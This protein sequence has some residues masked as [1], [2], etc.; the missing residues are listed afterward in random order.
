[1]ARTQIKAQ[2]ILDH[3]LTGSSFRT[4]L[5]YYD[6]TQNYSQGAVISWA[7][8]EYQANTSIT[9]TTEGDL[10]NAPNISTN[11][12]KIPPVKCLIIPSVSQ[13]F[14]NTP[15]VMNLDTTILSDPFTRV[16]L[17]S[18]NK[19]IKFNITGDLLVDYSY[20][21]E[22]TTNNRTESSCW[23][24][25]SSDNGSNWTLIDNTKSY[26]YHRTTDA[27]AT[28]AT[29]LVPI[30]INTGDLIRL[31]MADSNTNDIKTIVGSNKITIFSTAGVSGPQGEKGD[32]GPSGDINWTGPWSSSGTYNINDAVYY[33][34]SSYVSTTNNNTE[35]PSD[36]ATN[37]DIL[38]SKGSDGSGTSITV[39][40][41]GTNLNN[42][43][44]ST[45]NFTGTL[46]SAVDA[47]GGTANIYALPTKMEYIQTIWAEENAALG[48]GNYEWAFGN[49]ANTPQMH[50]VVLYV[51][52]GYSAEVVALGLVV[53]S[54]SNDVVAEVQCELTDGTGTTRAAGSVTVDIP[55]TSSI[56][57]VVELSTPVS[58]VSGEALNFKTISV[59]GS[60]GSPNVVTAYLKYTEN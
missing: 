37:W 60:S 27:G 14:N 11:W 16:E 38:A 31:V 21:A 18:T 52:S 40:D 5:R 36:T 39:A 13:T 44:H 56:K 49:G 29:M 4:E 53:T 50:G 10:S 17:D 22:S 57:N 58:F 42:T 28:T 48:S 30:S 41:N 35:T 47:G 54:S 19:A 43:P 51:P 24:E 55:T 7:G 34:G 6:E 15:T 12:D 23:L 33:L 8:R 32:V 1:M 20:T 9:G 3:S 59:T 46:I 25:K 45:L 2:N 26:A